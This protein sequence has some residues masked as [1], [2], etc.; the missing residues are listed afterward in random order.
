MYKCQHS[1]TAAAHFTFEDVDLEHSHHESLKGLYDIKLQWTP[2]PNL[3]RPA[4]LGSPVGAAPPT[5]A[6]PDPSDVSI[7]TAVQEQLGLKLNSAKGPVKVLVID[8][9]S[10][11]R[12]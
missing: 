9:A 11:P 4:G 3:G 8:S 5:S 7:F 1:Q 10:R 12:E 2:D 6:A